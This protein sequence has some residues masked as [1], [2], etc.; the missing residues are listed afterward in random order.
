MEIV[1][2]TK[3]KTAGVA[4]VCAL[5]TGGAATGAAQQ[6]IPDYSNRNMGSAIIALP[7]DVRQS[8]AKQKAAMRAIYLE[9]TET[10]R[11]SLTNWDYGAASV[12]TAYFAES[13]FYRQE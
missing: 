11:G 1:E 13:H 6:A 4:G 5:L 9:F 7:P 12:Y 2:W 8:L 3:L 10:S